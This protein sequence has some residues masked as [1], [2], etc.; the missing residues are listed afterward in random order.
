MAGKLTEA[1]FIVGWEVSFSFSP[2][3]LQLRTVSSTGDQF[4]VSFKWIIP[5]VFLSFCDIF[6]NLAE[7]SEHKLNMWTSRMIFSKS[8]A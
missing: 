8:D 2:F 3:F 5:T 7:T 1:F 4:T 6:L